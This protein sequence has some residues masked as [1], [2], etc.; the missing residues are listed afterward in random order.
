MKITKAKLKQIIKE[1]LGK[2]SEG[3]RTKK[4]REER[5]KRFNAQMEL[6]D[7]ADKKAAEMG[8]PAQVRFDIESR[9]YWI[10][11]A[12]TEE[13]MWPAEESEEESDK[14]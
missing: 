6:R 10:V 14:K 5:L 7:V 3:R 4:G 13:K 1:E 12:E 9:T 8:W 2:V 11:N